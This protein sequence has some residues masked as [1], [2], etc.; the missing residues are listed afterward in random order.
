MGIRR[1]EYLTLLAFSF[2]LYLT[3]G[4]WLSA[5]LLAAVL[6]AVP[7]S[8]LASLPAWAA[9]RL[10]PEDP[11]PLTVGGEAKVR[12]CSL[13]ILPCPPYRGKIYMENRLTGE[14]RTVREG[15]ALPTEHCGGWT[16]RGKSLWMGDYLGLLS[17]PIPP[18]GRVRIPVRPH[19]LPLP[20]SMQWILHA[21]ERWKPRPAGGFSENHEHRSYRPGDEWNRI[22]WK[23]SAKT[24]QLIVREAMEPVKGTAELTLTLQGTPEELDRRLGRLLWAGE[25]VLA[26]GMTLRIRVLTGDGPEGFTAACREELLEAVDR[27]LFLKPASEEPAAWR[28]SAAVYLGGEADEN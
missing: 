4:T 25:Q 9:D 2:V 8:L 23:L 14:K 19:P 16:L 1:L 20:E 15:S 24:D 5:I 21:P 13:G 26:Q 6:A 12:L 3:E 11:G 22:H 10:Q 27:I 28:E 7:L 17:I 18:V